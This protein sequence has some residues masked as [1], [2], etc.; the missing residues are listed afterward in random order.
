M[1]AGEQ[2]VLRSE[3]L[4][5]SRNVFGGSEARF[6]ILQL[7]AAPALAASPRLPSN[8]ASVPQPDQSES[9]GERSFDLSG[10][11]INQK[12]MDMSRIDE[13][14]TV[15]TTETWTVRNRDS[16]HHNFHVHDVRFRILEIA[17]KAPPPVLAGWKDTVWVPAGEDVRLMMRFEDYAD[18]DSP[19]MF[20]C[21]MLR[22]E[23]RG[24]MGQFVVVQKGESAGRVDHT[25]H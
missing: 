17:G 16:N 25:H 6:D 15:G 3:K 24:M 13:T 2:T 23:D 19:Y 4:E 22:H 11:D 7:R 12:E 10:T 21:H 20:H 5:G 1:K 9:T 18:K 14:V 8:L